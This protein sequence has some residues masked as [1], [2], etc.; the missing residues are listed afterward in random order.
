MKITTLLVV[1]LMCVA[2]LIPY[3]ESLQYVRLTTGGSVN[4]P[5]T[6]YKLAPLAAVSTVQSVAVKASGSTLYVYRTDTA[7]PIQISSLGFPYSIR[8]LT[9][10]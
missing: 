4:D 7:T 8:R 2:S 9:P 1:C 10:R 5:L 3:A 6:S